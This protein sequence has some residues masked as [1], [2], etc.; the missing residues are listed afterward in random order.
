M[1][2][3]TLLGPLPDCVTTVQGHVVKE[4][5]VG[6]VFSW[7]DRDRQELVGG[8]EDAV[9]FVSDEKTSSALGRVGGCRRRRPYLRQRRLSG[10][11][12]V[13]RGR[14]RNVRGD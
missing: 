7:H 3:K 12:L 9:G 13:L 10:P 4:M 11:H 14:T 1:G 5:D 8:P 2:G 6:P